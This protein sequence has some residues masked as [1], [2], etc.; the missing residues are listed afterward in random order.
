MAVAAE[1]GGGARRWRQAMG[2]VLEKNGRCGWARKAGRQMVKSEEGEAPCETPQQ[3][4]NRRE[5]GAL[6]N[7]RAVG[8]QVKKAEAG[9]GKG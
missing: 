9:Y 1:A 5:G 3:R 8:W 6:C 2:A 7:S 4:L